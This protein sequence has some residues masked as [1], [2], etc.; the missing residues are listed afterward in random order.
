MSCLGCKLATN[1]EDSL[2]LA[3]RVQ[4]VRDAA[5]DPGIDYSGY[6]LLARPDI[7]LIF[8]E[9]YGSILYQ[10]ESLREPYLALLNELQS[11][12]D[13]A[14]WHSASALSE[15]PTWGGGSWMA[16]TSALFGLRVDSHPAYLALRDRF[17]TE[18]YPTLSLIHI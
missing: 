13:A 14:G 5:Y 12:L 9:S 10:K 2:A 17:A 7:Y 6:D 1:I 15:S 4:T 8:I 11:D 3:T 18:A 16:Y